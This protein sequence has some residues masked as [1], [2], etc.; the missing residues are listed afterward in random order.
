LAS[1]IAGRPPRAC[2]QSDAPAPQHNSADPI[3]K[4]QVN[5]SHF[6]IPAQILIMF[7]RWYV[8]AQELLEAVGEPPVLDLPAVHLACPDPHRPG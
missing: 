2:T 4:S 8:L 3:S 1:P 6:R 7:R 5:L